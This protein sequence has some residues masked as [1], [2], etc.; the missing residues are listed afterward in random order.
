MPV[1]VLANI[2]KIHEQNPIQRSQ[3]RVAK[4]IPLNI[5]RREPSLWGHEIHEMVQVAA[6]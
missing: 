2:R 1:C 3:V 4:L 6:Y 5:Y